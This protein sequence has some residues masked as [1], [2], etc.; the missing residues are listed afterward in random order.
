MKPPWCPQSGRVL[1][2]HDWTSHERIRCPECLKRVTV[3]AGRVPK[4][5]MPAVVAA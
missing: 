3:V 2:G 1:P 4:H 5:R